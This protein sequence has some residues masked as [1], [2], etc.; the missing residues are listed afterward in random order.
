MPSKEITAI[1]VYN[2][3]DP[4][5]KAVQ[6]AYH[7]FNHDWLFQYPCQLFANSLRMLK[8]FD[9]TWLDNSQLLTNRISYFFAPSMSSKNNVLVFLTHLL[10]VR[11][12]VE[13]KSINSV[14]HN[15]IVLVTKPLSHYLFSEYP[16][17]IYL[18]GTKLLEK[19]KLS[20]IGGLYVTEDFDVD[21]EGCIVEIDGNNDPFLVQQFN[22]IGQKA[23]AS[24]ISRGV[25]KINEEDKPLKPN[26][27]IWDKR[28]RESCLITEIEPGSTGLVLIR[29]SDGTLRHVVKQDFDRLYTIIA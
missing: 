29:Y 9:E 26:M 20:K 7:K 19:N 28:L 25:F 15:P 23:A 5:E 4:L 16:V 13:N 18:D 14:I 24:Q 3:V 2:P 11:D 12:I 22:F 27:S 10:F 17:K 1:S 21:I 8:S 6:E